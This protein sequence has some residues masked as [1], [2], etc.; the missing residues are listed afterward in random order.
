MAK[1]KRRIRI[2]NPSVTRLE[3]EAALELEARGDRLEKLIL[4]IYEPPRLFEKLLE[5]RDY[6][7][8]PTLTARICGICP[9]AYQMTA[10]G[11]IEQ[12]FAIAPTD[13]IRQMRRVIYCG[14]WL[15]SHSLH[16][17]FLALPDFTGHDTAFA[18]AEQSPELFQ[19]G[20]RLQQLGNDLMAL[21][22]GRA[23]HPV[24]VVVGGFTAA[25]P[26]ERVAKMIE[27]LEQGR[28]DAR[29]LLE[30]VCQLDLP[31]DRQDFTNVALVHDSDYPIHE[32]DIASSTGLR[33]PATA[34]LQHFKEHQEPHS[35]ALYS[36]LEGEPYLVGPLA[37][38]NLNHAKLP[39]EIR[40]L[41]SQQGI[42]WPSA[43]LYHSIIARAAECYLAVLEALSLLRDYRVPGNCQLPVA[44]KAGTGM[45]CT[46][47]PR[48]MIWHRYDLDEAGQVK[49]AT[50]VPPTSQNQA[51]IEQDLYQAVPRFG[52]QHNEE[53]LR[54]YC[55]TRIRNY[56]PCISCSTHF[57]DLR[58]RRSH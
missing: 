6:P 5:G 37:R 12:I 21:F 28:E 22:G 30:A 56:D 24:A 19:R 38:M 8:V 51:R 31:R 36:L 52:L 42:Q 46:E 57:L 43:N 1:S 39:A 17:H 33:I 11:A 55:E 2:H 27:R 9:I 48:G 20:L 4:R 49:L 15:Q 23:V 25:P 34:Y 54:R 41:L 16:I 32:G 14:E 18:M 10:I 3:G 47:A 44:V 35:T 50:I 29:D 40:S 7:D 58:L 53:A 13:W 45:Y 26:A